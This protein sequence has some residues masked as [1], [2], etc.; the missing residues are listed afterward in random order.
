MEVQH[1]GYT[2][3]DDAARLDLNAIH[4]Y[5]QHSYWAATRPKE[6]IARSLRHSLCIGVYDSAGA[7]VGL[8]RVVS[9]Y[10]TFAYL[11]DVYV[12]EDHR[13][14]GLAKAALRFIDAHPA[15]QNLRRFH[16]V[17]AD[18]HGLY[19]QFGFTAIA[20]PERHMERRT[21]G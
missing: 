2:I 14:R 3:S 6:V 21:H 16:L 8:A 4:G 18:A 20:T 13:G 1:A 10:S 5:L 19:A 15:L 11:C 7:Q 9:D 17:T 12:L